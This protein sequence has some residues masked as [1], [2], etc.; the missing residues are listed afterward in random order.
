MTLLQL[1]TLHQ[2]YLMDEIDY[3]TFSNALRSRM[4]KER[5]AIQRVEAAVKLMD[6]KEKQK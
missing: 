3:A 6:R 4:L 1:A 5:M 2:K